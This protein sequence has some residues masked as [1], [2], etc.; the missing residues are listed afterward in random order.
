MR[1]GVPASAAFTISWSHSA[2]RLH[3][4]ALDA[5]LPA[6]APRRAAN[7]P[8]AGGARPG[9]R[10]RNGTVPRNPRRALR[11]SGGA[12]DRGGP[13]CARRYLRT[14]PRPWARGSGRCGSGGP[15]PVAGLAGVSCGGRGD[16]RRG[17]EEVSA[18]NGPG[19]GPGRFHG[20][21]AGKAL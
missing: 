14:R 17:S 16:R 7:P 5:K 15:P 10:V 12:E 19:A 11:V 3:A 18:P 20:A 2:S 6:I 8:P 4:P 21:Q 13:G 9:S 1:R